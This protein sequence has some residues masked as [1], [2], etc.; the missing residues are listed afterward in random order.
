MTAKNTPLQDAKGNLKKRLESV[1]GRE[2]ADIADAE[3]AAMTQLD[4]RQ[5]LVRLAQHNLLKQADYSPDRR[6]RMALM[7]IER[8]QKLIKET[9]GAYTLDELDAITGR[10]LHKAALMQPHNT[11]AP[12]TWQRT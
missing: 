11:L 12:C 5:V 3:A 4:D 6:A 8:F 10:H 2:I 7:A 1:L 9:G